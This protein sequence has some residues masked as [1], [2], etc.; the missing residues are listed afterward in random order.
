MAIGKKKT[1][2]GLSPIQMHF[3]LKTVKANRLT[4]NN[5][6]QVHFILINKLKN[7]RYINTAN[8]ACSRHSTAKR[9]IHPSFFLRENAHRQ[10]YWFIW[11]VTSFIKK[12]RR[13]LG[14][15]WPKYMSVYK[16][17][18]F[19][20]F[21]SNPIGIPI[22][23]NVL[24][25]HPQNLSTYCSNHRKMVL[26]KNPLLHCFDHHHAW[27]MKRLLPICWASCIRFRHSS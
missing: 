22:Y 3:D 16:W 9:A 7:D 17:N 6:C 2:E 26:P 25:K 11:I 23:D 19:Y 13:K 5:A 8:Q 15:Y 1:P 10:V 12:S 21:M 18:I 20:Y 27:T 14:V 24:L 4:P